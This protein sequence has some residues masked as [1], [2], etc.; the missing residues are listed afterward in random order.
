MTVLNE[1]TD[2]QYGMARIR[3][4]NC[5]ACQKKVAQSDTW[6][7]IPG[8]HHLVKEKDEAPTHPAKSRVDKE[9]LDFCCKD[10]LISYVAPE[11][12]EMLPAKVETAVSELKQI[13]SVLS[14]GHT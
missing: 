10:C 2:T 8:W 14:G 9:E 5:D 7:V 3:I 6:T 1:E 11:L 12:F 4:V 13:E